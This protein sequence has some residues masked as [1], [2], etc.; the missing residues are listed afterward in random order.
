M[1]TKTF[2]IREESLSN[3]VFK[4]GMWIMQNAGF[5]SLNVNNQEGV[6]L[7]EGELDHVLDEFM[8]FM[9]TLGLEEM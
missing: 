7:F 2:R 4:I 8:K 5:V 9:K 3:D 6:F 1:A